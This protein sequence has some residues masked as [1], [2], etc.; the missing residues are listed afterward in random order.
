MK[1]KEG[2]LDFIPTWLPE[3]NRI[4]IDEAVS[5]TLRQE[6]S[7]QT[8][9]NK[10]I[11]KNYSKE[12]IHYF[13]HQLSKM[14]DE[15]GSQGDFPH[16][17]TRYLGTLVYYQSV[18]KL[19]PEKGL[20]KLIGKAYGKDLQLG[21]QRRK[22]VKEF[23]Q[24]GVAARKSNIKK[25]REYEVAL[26]NLHRKKPKLTYSRLCELTAVNFNVSSKTIQR[27]TKNPHK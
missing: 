10:T 7:R 23:S 24:K 11:H 12:D 14:V 17:M 19:G 1:K 22:Q 2:V 8:A 3:A 21:K 5:Q 9:P 25:W 27:H 4:E 6:Y 16:T 20:E 18:I 26:K 15:G 13:M